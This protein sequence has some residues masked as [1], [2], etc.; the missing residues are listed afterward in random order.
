MQL[1]RVAARS[2]PAEFYLG[3]QIAGLFEGGQLGDGTSEL[4]APVALRGL[5]AVAG[6]RRTRAAFSIIYTHI[7]LWVFYYFAF[8]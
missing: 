2:P 7:A 6:T 8:R 4:K 3:L 1:G 5:R